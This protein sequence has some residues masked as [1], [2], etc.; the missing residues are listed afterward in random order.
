[1]KYAVGACLLFAT[2][3]LAQPTVERG[4]YIVRNVAVCGSCHSSDPKNPDAP[5]SGGKE[6]RDWRIGVARASNLTPDVD[7]GLGTW[8][9]DDIVRA[10]RTG[11]RKSGRLLAPVMPYEWFHDMSDDDARAVARYLKSMP[12]VRNEVKQSPNIAFKL[13]KLF[14]R[15]KAAQSM[16]APPRAAT[17]ASGSY[18]SQHVG[19]CAECHTPRS[20][21]LNRPDR[22]RL[23]GGVENP[24][25]DFPAKPSNLRAIGNWTEADFIRTMRTGVDPAGKKLNPIMPWPENARMTDDDLRAFYRYLMT[26]QSGPS[27]PR[28]GPAASR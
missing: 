7:T 5:L 8:S 1:M 4:A 14:L 20:G 13:G 15:P 21:L 3:A 6:F 10:L 19:L 12:P 11:Q 26:I 18:L 17:P 2:A 27:S 28:S 16:T 24:P 23:F 9:E 25:K 22:S